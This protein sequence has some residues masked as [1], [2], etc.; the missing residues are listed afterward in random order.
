MRSF[1]SRAKRLRFESLEPKTLLAADLHV[2]VAD[3]DLFIV[4][5]KGN[6]NLV[7]EASTESPGAWTIT[8][9][10]NDAINGKAP[11]E[12]VVVSD[13]SGTIWVS[14]RDGN[15]SLTVKGTG[16]DDELVRSLHVRGS[17]GENRIL[18]SDLAVGNDL[19]VRTRSS[20]DRIDLVRTVV[21]DQTAIRTGAGADAIACED[22]V[23]GGSLDI[24]A[25]GGWY[26]DTA[27]IADTS[28]GSNFTFR[29]SRGNNELVV[30]TTDVGERV[31]VRLGDGDDCVRIGVNAPAE[32]LMG[33]TF[34]R[35]TSVHARNLQVST[36]GGED[37]V[38]IFRT[39]VARHVRTQ[40]GDQQDRLTIADSRVGGNCLVEAGA[41]DDLFEAGSYLPDEGTLVSTPWPFGGETVF[42]GG[43]GNDQLRYVDEGDV[44]NEQWLSWEELPEGTTDAASADTCTIPADSINALAADLYAQF[45]E[46]GENLVFSP[47]SISA[48]LAMVY[49]GAEG[50]TAAEMAEVLH[51]PENSAEFHAAYGELLNSLNEADSLEGL[52]LNVANSLWTQT[53][54]PFSEE[55]LDQILAEYGGGA[56]DVDFVRDSEG[57]R[58]IINQWVEDQTNDQIR[59]LIP[60]N[61]LTDE[62]VLVLANAIYFDATWRHEFDQYLTHPAAFHVDS[63]EEIVV[64][65]MH[66]RSTYRYLEQDGVQYVELPYSDGRFSMVVALP[67]EG[68]S[69]SQVDVTAVTDDLGEFLSGME[70]Q[71]VA[72]SLPKFEATSTPNAKQALNDL[73]IEDLFD[74]DVS[75]LDGMKDPTAQL[76]GNLWVQD[77][78]H[79][80]TIELDEAGT[81]A[82]AA[83]A[84]VVCYPTGIL[85]DSLQVNADHPFLYFIC[86]TQTDTIAFM[87]QVSCPT[88]ST[89]VQTLS[90]S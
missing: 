30:E 57:A 44:D 65:M 8:P 25:G 71:P 4:G 37:A 60:P 42:E 62:T 3:G 20:S 72:V 7:I 75:D 48:A 51:F 32:R 73:G 26:D 88:E 58:K 63:E 52:E 59:E 28:V 13:V 22:L 82:A 24:Y 2:S 12:A 89:Q 81:T 53:G 70:Y 35:F 55:Y 17:L 83:T 6:D 74:R 21:G 78:I 40:L 41:G 10:G 56:T 45:A 64:D 85:S 54:F 86:D 46:S 66:D 84:V 34:E 9:A 33:P 38:E 29:A 77:I 31:R 87:G 79:K 76:D 80:A 61:V 69:L 27:S 36:E 11:G 47:L 18:V 14:L 90:A 49:A 16:K 67:S 5:S 19:S 1:H 23:V 15:D 68:M 50:D 43:E 39:S